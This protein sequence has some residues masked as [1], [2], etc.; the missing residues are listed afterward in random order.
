MTECYDVFLGN[1]AVGK[2]YAD[3][4]GLYCRFRCRCH[5]AGGSICS[6]AV[7]CANEEIHLGILVPAGDAF[8]LETRIPVKRLPEGEFRFVLLPRHRELEGKFI[9]LS[10]QEPFA[11]LSRLKDA[12]LEKRDGSIGIVIPGDGQP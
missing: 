1:L 6:L 10:P 5:V 7:L 9:P 12:Y 8:V 4:Q 11:Y 2:V 3:R